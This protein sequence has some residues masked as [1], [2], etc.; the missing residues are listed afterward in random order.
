MRSGSGFYGL[1][2]QFLEGA[3]K[4]VGRL[5]RN[6][7]VWGNPGTSIFASVALQFANSLTKLSPCQNVAWIRHQNS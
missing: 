5:I 7:L 6:R 1:R 4:S 2:A 3:R